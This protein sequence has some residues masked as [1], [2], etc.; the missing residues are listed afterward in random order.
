MRECGECTACCEGWVE[1]RLEVAG[2][3]IEMYPSKPCDHCT[4]SG[5][6]IY[7]D[8]PEDP[9]RIFNCVWLQ[10]EAEFPEDMRPDRS[11]AIVLAGRPWR[12]W[13][14][15]QATPVGAEIPPETLERLRVYTQQKEVPLVFYEREVVDGRFTGNG[16]QRAFGSEK[17]AEAVKNQVLASDVVKL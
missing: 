8:R 11:G 15:L 7:E 9:C 5:C 16:R 1:D 4:G 2:Q 6:A 17:F 3:V 12:E 10:N 13:E 14:V